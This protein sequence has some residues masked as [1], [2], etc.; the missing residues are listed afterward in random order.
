MK[1]SMVYNKAASLIEK[2]WTRGVYARNEK[3][4]ECNT[5][6]ESAVR[7]CVLGSLNFAS[8]IYHVNLPGKL[9]A[10]LEVEESLASWNDDPFRTQEEVVK[11]LKDAAVRADEENMTLTTGL[12]DG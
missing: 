3:G 12:S 8:H 2:G 6:G 9:T 10:Y 4:F 1:Y 11:L 5:Y 7:W